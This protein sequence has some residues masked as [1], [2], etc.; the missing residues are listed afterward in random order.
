MQFNTFS[1]T[2]NE[3]FCNELQISDHFKSLQIAQNSLKKSSVVI[4]FQKS[5]SGF[6]CLQ[7]DDFSANL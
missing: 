4:D 3:D 2:N 1:V 5:F 6:K 7:N